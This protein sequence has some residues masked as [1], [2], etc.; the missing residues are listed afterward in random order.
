MA[1]EEF[2]KESTK[3][4]NQI[5]KDYGIFWAFDNKQFEENKTPLEEGDKYVRLG[6]GG[7]MP[8]SKLQSFR[9]AEKEFFE[10][11]WKTI[12][13]NNWKELEILYELRNHECFYGGDI[14]YILEILPYDEAEIMEVYSKHRKTEIK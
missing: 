10:K 6:G 1:Y 13:E 2:K 9:N 7:F 8:K 14:E 4:Y 5:F 11:Y 3:K 12:E